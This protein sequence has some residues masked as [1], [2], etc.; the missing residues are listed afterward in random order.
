M[1]SVVLRAR[2]E[3]RWI[4][5][6]LAALSLQSLAP[7]DMILVDNES[8]DETVPIARRFGA[9]ILAVSREAFSYGHALNIGIEAARHEVVALLSAHCIPVDEL[10][11]EYLLA[12][13]ADAGQGDL[14]GVYGRQEPLPETGAADR[15]DLWTT[16]RHARLRQRGDFFFH[17]ANAAIR[18]DVWRAIPFDEALSGVEDRAWARRVL[19]AGHAI[20]YEPRAR[21]YHHHGIHQGGAGERAERVAAVLADLEAAAAGQAV[22]SDR[23]AAPARP[24]PVAAG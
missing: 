7:L 13:L 15:R 5:R 17:N 22:Q 24:A 18:R 20:A 16:F 1:I 2:N 8:E 11:A 12:N 23:L 19:A 14:A 6:C 10:W 9:R 21:V 3:A 4:R